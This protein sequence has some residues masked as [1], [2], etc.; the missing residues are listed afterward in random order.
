[1]K[2]LPMMIAVALFGSCA[3]SEASVGTP[4]RQ[5]RRS[6]LRAAETFAAV[7]SERGDLDT[8][9]THDVVV[10]DPAPYGPDDLDVLRDAGAL[11]LGYVNVGEVEAW[12]PF[13]DRVDPAW[14]LGENPNWPGHRFVDAREPG[15]RE[16]VVETAARDVAR[17]GFDGLFLDM[18]DVAVVY[19]ETADGV[20]ALVRELRAAY[21][22]LALVINRGFPLLDR[23]GDALDGLLVEGVW[24][25][26]DFATDGVRATPAEER[27][28][29]L[30]HLL[31]F[32]RAGGA[33]FVIDYAQTD[34]QRASIRASARRAGLPVH[35]GTVA[36]GRL[37]EGVEPE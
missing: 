8:L 29:L 32:Q 26:P 15:W 34:A 25:G 17:R 4:E 7:L 27:D 20:V 31:S 2:L 16:I 37:R 11:T 5:A 9:A 21:P 13:A 6:A 14:V 12:R 33:A 19:P 23:L 1:M 30:G 10:L 18:A 24:M 3:S 22:D 35:V 36:L 28:A